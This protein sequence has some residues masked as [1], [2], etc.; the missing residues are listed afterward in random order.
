MTGSPLHWQDWAVIS[1]YAVLSIGCALWFARRKN[2]ATGD[3]YMVAGRRLPWWVVGIADIAT[4]DGADSY[5]IFVF[6]TGG[7]IAYYRFFWIYGIV[8]LP[9]QVIWARYWRRLHLLSPGQI[10]EER[11][12]GK[13]AARFR[14]FSSVY[15]ALL[16]NGV[17]IGYVLQ[18]FAQAMHPFLG[19]PPDL[20][21][22]CFFGTTMAYTLLSGLLAVAY[23][24][25]AQFILVMGGRILLAGVLLHAAGG[26][27]AVLDRV[28]QVRGAAFLQP[29]PPSLP[30]NAGL[31]GD[32][33]VDPLS[34]VALLLLGLFRVADSSSPVVQRALA[35]RNEMHAAVGQVFNAVL[36]LAA[37]TLPMI[38]VG[39]VA[40]ALL[41]AGRKDT[42]QWADLLRAHV[43]PGLLGLFL[44]GII[45]GYMSTLDG[46]I[47]FGAAGMLNDLY[48]RHIHK[49]ASDRQQVAFGRV[50]TLMVM[51]MSYLWARVLIGKI[52]G[53]WINF[54]GS[55]ALLVV[56]PVSLLRW[57]WWRLNI[58]GEVIGFLS[59]FPVA[60]AVWFGCGPI[61][62]FK[63]R[64]YWQA[65]SLLL[66]VGTAVIV[67][68]TLC[69]P[70]ERPEVLLRF[71]L[72]AR[73]PGFWGPV[74]A[75]AE[76]GNGA[77]RDGRRRHELW[78]DLQTALCG[79][80]FCA[81]LV[82]GMSAGI[83]RHFLLCG[84][85]GV[86]AAGLAASFVFLTI[87]GERL[88]RRY[89]AHAAQDGPG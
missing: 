9:V 43:G 45:A 31:H 80:A 39:L 44:V 84:V 60:Y 3:D 74:A 4:G 76:E 42:D 51:G 61:P 83:S 85:L 71:Y 87:R 59:S 21:L 12:G 10:Y 55:V 72:K 6:F 36:S 38:L 73:P 19:W 65:F 63:D 82:V 17:L 5:W 53:A 70:P 88:R 57:T 34:L 47:N 62:A 23:T 81:S 15:G 40:V 8:L 35:A 32:F 69:T 22:L 77:A 1:V 29:Y 16:T 37:R 27:S 13:M 33:A 54:I 30:A 49:D 64:P 11:Y 78:Q 46:L 18:G 41:P 28:E 25:V 67:A 50:A 66:G 52:D 68:V 24:D 58:W 56:L 48:R 26:L 89:E 86:A 2:H 75:A 7:L 20:V 14:A 79:T